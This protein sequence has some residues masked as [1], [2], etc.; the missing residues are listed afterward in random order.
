VQY[1]V[2]RG[3]FHQSRVLLNTCAVTLVAL[4]E[5]GSD[6]PL[7][8]GAM[9]EGRYPYDRIAFDPGTFWSAVKTAFASQP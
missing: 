6:P 8:L 2:E 5:I 1:R 7:V 4:S 3:V 9:G